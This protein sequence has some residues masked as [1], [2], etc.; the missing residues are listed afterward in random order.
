V[1]E[2]DRPRQIESAAEHRAIRPSEQRPPILLVCTAA[3]TYPPVVRNNGMS[4][5]I[6]RL[7]GRSL[8]ASSKASD[9]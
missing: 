2:V 1:A 3:P 9:G 4:V 7:D 6:S 8:I 5:L